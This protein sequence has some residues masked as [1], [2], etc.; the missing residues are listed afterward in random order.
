[1]PVETIIAG[2]THLRP[3]PDGGRDI[4]VAAGPNHVYVV[5]IPE[6]CLADLATALT[7]D[8]DALARE[9]S[10]QQASARLVVPDGPIQPSTVGRPG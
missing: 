8:E 6:E 9:H 3:R 1:M 7:L 10:R 5:P 2:P 4:L